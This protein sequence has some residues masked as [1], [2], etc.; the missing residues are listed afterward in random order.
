MARTFDAL[1]L[2]GVDYKDALSFQETLL[3]RRVRGEIGDTLLLLE[4]PSVITLG[5]GAN[6]ENVLLDA[7]DAT[8]RGVGI[9]ETG[10]GGDVTFHGPGQL[11]GYPIFSLS[12]DREDVRRYVR[13]LGDI[14][15]ALAKLEGIRAAHVIDDKDKIGVWVD[16]D[17]PHGHHW[18]DTSNPNGITSDRRIAKLGAIGVRISR[19]VTMHGFAFNVRTDLRSFQWIIPCG[20]S[21]YGVCSVEAIAGGKPYEKD[22]SRWA[23]LATEEFRKTFAAEGRYF[24]GDAALQK[25]NEALGPHDNPRTLPAPSQ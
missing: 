16:Q 11:V 19:W 13:D 20:I 9:V 10:R 21:Q 22:L 14:M 25:L 23:E 1:W 24:A 15:I 5:R 2:G 6:H 12:P 18:T 3:E 8:A 4:H 7:A 17:D